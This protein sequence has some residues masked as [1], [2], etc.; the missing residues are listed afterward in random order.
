M[1]QLNHNG[2]ITLQYNFYVINH[3]YCHIL[4]YYLLFQILN[5]GATRL[6][7]RHVAMWLTQL[8]FTFEITNS[9]MPGAW[10]LVPNWWTG[11][12]T[13]G[14]DLL[15]LLVKLVGGGLIICRVNKLYLICW[16]FK[17]NNQN[18]LGSG[19]DTSGR[20]MAF[21]QWRPGSNPGTNLGFLKFRNAVNPFS[22]GVWL[23]LTAC[24]RTVHALP[25]S[26]LFP[27][28]IY[29]SKK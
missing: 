13:V 20:A 22:Q 29:Y 17:F 14:A 28:I 4:I 27:I 23:F 11:I 12:P 24:N 25:S 19:G 1:H 16:F 2:V 8:F 18:T 7:T 6:T 26:F 9:P 15:T 5:Y 10:C 21:C 3:C